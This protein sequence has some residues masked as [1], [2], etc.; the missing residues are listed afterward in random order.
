MTMLG[1]AATTDVKNVPVVIADGDRTQTSRRL[2]AR[3]D[4]SPNFTGIDTVSSVR[5]VD[6]YLQ[7]GEAWIAVGIPQ[8]Y[9]DAIQAGRPVS[10]QGVAD[11]SDSNSTTVALGYATA[12]VG[13]Y[14][15]EL[16]RASAPSAAAGQVPAGQIGGPID[17]RV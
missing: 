9:A 10:L 8:G 6:R 17:L 4:G 11:G 14:A 7:R 13:E 12:L 3:F 2:I 15:A 1:Y 5:E 16:A